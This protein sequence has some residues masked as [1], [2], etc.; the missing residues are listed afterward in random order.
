MTARDDRADYVAGL[1]ALADFIETCTELP[2]P[3]IT[4]TSFH[5]DGDDEQSRAE[6]DRVAKVLKPSTTAGG[7][8]YSAIRWF[9]PVE[10]QAIAITADSQARYRKYMKG[11]RS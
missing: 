7:D 4:A 8:H 5:P 3:S 2:V 9:G 1:R 6:V 10:Y 11:W